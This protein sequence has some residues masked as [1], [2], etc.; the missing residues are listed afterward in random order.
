MFSLAVDFHNAELEIKK[1]TQKDT[2]EG[3][4]T[5]DIL[6]NQGTMIVNSV[7]HPTKPFEPKKGGPPAGGGH[8][9]V[10]V[11]MTISSNQAP[12]QIARRAATEIARL[13]TNRRS[14]GYA[15]NFTARN[16]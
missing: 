16:R 14:S 12:G 11:S 8:T 10:Y 2:L 7:L 15:P 4:G 9:N 13:A 5:A 1:Q 6:K 3:I